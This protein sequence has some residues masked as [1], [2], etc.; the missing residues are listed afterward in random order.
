MW[1]IGKVVV[2]LEILSY[3]GEFGTMLA[4]DLA[5]FSVNFFRPR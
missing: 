4:G 5:Y 3:Q 1:G 2:D